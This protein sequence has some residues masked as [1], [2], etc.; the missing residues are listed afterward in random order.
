MKR[1]VY[2]LTTINDMDPMRS[3]SE[4]GYRYDARTVGL[5]H[6][7]EDAISIAHGNCGDINEAGYYPYVVIERVEIGCLYP[8]IGIEERV[9]MRWDEELDGYVKFDGAGAPTNIC[10]YSTIG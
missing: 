9:W 3:A 7:V 1:A 6:T 10:N 8:G 5:F 2:A 4:R